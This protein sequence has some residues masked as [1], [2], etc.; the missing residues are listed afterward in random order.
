M[1]IKLFILFIVLT[2]ISSGCV[3]IIVGSVGALGGYA[4]T[5]DT[6]QGEYDA[7]YSKAWRSSLD[8]CG[9]LGRIVSKDT[10]KGIVDAEIENA[11]VRV[12]VTQLTPEAIRLKVKARKG[13]FPRLG[14]AEKVFVKIVQ[15]F[16]H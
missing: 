1:K 6:I 12:E 9:I 14:I 10:T 4:V 15:H 13:I 5:R 11:K 2:M 8:V 16:M 7:N 3:F